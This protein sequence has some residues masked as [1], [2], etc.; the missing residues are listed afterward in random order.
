MD[1]VLI[2]ADGSPTLGL[3]HITRCL[4]LA[5]AFAERS[6][7]PHFICKHL[8]SRVQQRVAEAGYACHP[9]PPDLSLE[10]D[11]D[12][13]A[14]LASERVARAVV[15]DLCNIAVTAQPVAYTGYLHRIAHNFSTIIID[16]LT[17]TV[18]PCAVVVNPN[19]GVDPTEYD[20]T[21]R[22]TLFLGP[23]Y[24]MLHP[25]FRGAAQAR[26][27][28]DGPVKTVAV[29]LGGG[30]LGYEVLRGVLYG[31]R[32]GLGPA[33]GVRVV[34]GADPSVATQL[35][36]DLVAFTGSCAV[37]SNLSHLADLFHE[38]D[39]AIVSGGVTKFES[40]AAGAATVMLAQV[41]H[42]EEWAKAFEKTGAAIYIGH[43][44]SVAPSSI[45]A[46]CR[47]LSED[48]PLRQRLVERGAAV[49]D[50]WGT[51]RVA[52]AVL[53]LPVTTNE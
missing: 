47:T 37:L 24:A 32:E 18:F 33:V 53:D 36:S 49:V 13:L 2:R 9:L 50:G 16:D 40:A 12:A 35:A 8:D 48:V 41:E 3:G 26:R 6:V 21:L 38:T 44:A 5:H 10:N 42:Q 46:I 25:A 28:P 11:A 23:A 43:A 17:R 7:R 29:A 30:I 45:A 52:Q 15:V 34:A 19:P 14:R 31:I 4:A 39:L 27:R 20:V 22:P 1:T 51:V